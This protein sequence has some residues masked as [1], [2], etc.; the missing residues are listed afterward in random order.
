MQALM[1]G[2]IGLTCMT[3]SDGWSG[4]MRSEDA[5]VRWRPGAVEF[6]TDA[7][8]QR[9][10]TSN[11]ALRQT[12]RVNKR[13]GVDLLAAGP[14]EDFALT[15][16]GERVSSTLPGWEVGEPTC[17]RLEHGELRLSLLLTRDGVQAKRTYVI[18]HGISLVRSRLEITNTGTQPVTVADPPIA[19]LS[20]PAREA[21]L[22]WM[23]GAEL[24][25]EPVD[26]DH[27]VA[28]DRF[29]MTLQGVRTTI[30]ETSDLV[31]S[32]TPQADHGFLLLPDI[33]DDDDRLLILQQR[34]RPGGE[35]AIQP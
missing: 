14:V 23:S 22:K 13:T 1:M 10:D 32:D 30:Q 28:G 17:E 11:G 24:F 21:D 7:M 33:T 5:I 25:G 35:L 29:R 26:I 3:A 15:I 31:E 4:E 20:H 16:N 34:S 8:R 19:A 2:V 6:G 18:H 12:V 27:P 9:L